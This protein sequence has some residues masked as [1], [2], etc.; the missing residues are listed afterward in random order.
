[1]FSYD[2]TEFFPILFSMLVVLLSLVRCICADEGGILSSSGYL[3]FDDAFDMW[4]DGCD[5]WPK[6]WRDYDPYSCTF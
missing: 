1:M 5:V 3:Y 2:V 6:M 4:D